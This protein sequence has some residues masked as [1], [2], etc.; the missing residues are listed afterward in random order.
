MLGYALLH[1][2]S[3]S[4]RYS[5]AVE[6]LGCNDDHELLTAL[7]HLYEYG[8]ILV[9]SE[10]V[11][12]IR[13][14]ANTPRLEMPPARGE[15]AVQT[16]KSQCGLTVNTGGAPKCLDDMPIVPSAPDFVEAGSA[17]F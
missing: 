5:L 10:S 12:E 17:F 11:R 9:S 8:L 2:P 6:I 4:G 16:F 1:P 14:E 15:A 3:G 7:A 13:P